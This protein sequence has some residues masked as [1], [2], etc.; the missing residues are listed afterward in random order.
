MLYNITSYTASI[1]SPQTFIVKVREETLWLV[2][3]TISTFLFNL[4]ESK[5]RLEVAESDTSP[6]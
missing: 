3:V 1:I 5:K 2:T 6:F 4:T